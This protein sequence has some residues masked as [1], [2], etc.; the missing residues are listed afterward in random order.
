[1]YLLVLSSRQALYFTYD[2]GGP[3]CREAHGV[4]VAS[5]LGSGIGGLVAPSCNLSLSEINPTA[6]RIGRGGQQGPGILT[7]VSSQ[8]QTRR[9]TSVPLVPPKPKLFLTATSIFMSRAVFAA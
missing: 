6:T 2:H 3:G 5:H 4:T 9:K 8:D 7:I 1:V